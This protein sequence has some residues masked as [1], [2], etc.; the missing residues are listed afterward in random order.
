MPT[1]YSQERRVLLAK[2]L[3][4]KVAKL[5]L[6]AQYGAHRSYSGSYTGV[7]IE[8]FSKRRVLFSCP[9]V[10][11]RECW[12]H[13]DFKI[14]VVL[15]PV[16]SSRRRAQGIDGLIT[17]STVPLRFHR[18]MPLRLLQLRLEQFVILVVQSFVYRELTRQVIIVA[19]T[20][21]RCQ[22]YPD[23]CLPNAMRGYDEGIAVLSDNISCLRQGYNLEDVCFSS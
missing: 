21:R 17:D 1:S 20:S 2:E 22:V 8:G 9:F 14:W 18:S 7:K 3:V 23:A 11:P 10:S 13:A 15:L 5:Y 16:R 6:P 19:V 12:L 4:E